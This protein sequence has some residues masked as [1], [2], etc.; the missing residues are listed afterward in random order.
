[1]DFSG[2]V[3]TLVVVAANL[4]FTPLS[5]KIELL[6]EALIFAPFTMGLE[7]IFCRIFGFLFWLVFDESCP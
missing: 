4:L 3:L 2:S 7:F 1:M 6:G 5:N